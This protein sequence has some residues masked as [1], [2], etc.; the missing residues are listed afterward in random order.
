MEFTNLIRPFTN[1]LNR[2]GGDGR[3]EGDEPKA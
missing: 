1:M 3:K 2:D